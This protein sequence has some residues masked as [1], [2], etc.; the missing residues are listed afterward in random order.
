V[1]QHKEISTMPDVTPFLWFGG[2][3]EE[4]VQFYVSVFPNSRVTNVMRYSQDGP[5]PAGHVMTMEFELDGKPL[6]AIND[7]RPESAPPDEV[8]FRQG[9][10][11]LYVDC[12][13]QD[14]VDDLWTKLGAGGRE[15]PC[16]WIQDRYGF[17]W[18]IVPTGLREVLSGDNEERSRRALHAMLQ[19]GKLDINELRRVYAS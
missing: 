9:K 7:P 15:L 4:A 19:M 18:N 13:T 16:G 10:I 17:A 11:A 8:E 6:M 1:G 3:A 12:E 14:V 2:D 5:G